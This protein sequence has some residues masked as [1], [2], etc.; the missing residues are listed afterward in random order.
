VT[1]ALQ[2]NGYTVRWAATGPDGLVQARAPGN[3][4]VIIDRML[5]KLDGLSLVKQLRAEGYSGPILIA[6]YDGG[7]TDDRV[8][9]LEAG[10]DDYLGKPFATNELLARVNALLRRSDILAARE[11][12]LRVGDLELDLVNQKTFRMGRQI[13]L[14]H[15]E[16]RLLR[17]LVENAGRVVTRTM[18]LE[19]VWDVSFD[20]RSNIVESHVSRLRAKID[21][22]SAAEMIQ[23]VRGA[24]YTIRA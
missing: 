23:T 2:K 17:Y 13:E 20:P 14:Q 18:L 24:G 6:N 10:A 7:D 5:P 1:E 4:L 9:G 12:T 11:T 15:Q 19:N 3:K 22:G 21:R 8:E 16:F